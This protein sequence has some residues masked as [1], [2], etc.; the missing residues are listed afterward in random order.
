[1]EIRHLGRSGLKVSTL[2]LGTMNFGSIGKYEE[3]GKVEKKEAIELVKIAID[4]GINFFDSSDIY[5]YG[6]SEEI[7]GN[8]LGTKRKEAIISTKVRFKVGTRPNDEGNSRYHIIEACNNSLRRLKTDYIDVYLLH[9]MDLHTPLEESLRAL[10]DLVRI[11]KV[12]YIGVSNYTGWQLMKALSISEKQNLERFIVYQGHYSIVSRD[13]ENEIVPLC[14]DQGLGVMVWSPLSGGFLTGKFK[15]DVTFPKNTRFGDFNKSDF[16][17]PV[18]YEKAFKILEKIEKIAQKHSVS[19]PQVS[20]NYLLEK[21]AVSSVVL[22]VRT[23][24][25]LLDN[26]N[27]K[28]WKISKEEVMELDDISEKTRPYPYW[29]QIITGFNK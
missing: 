1:M 13:L 16:V 2:C 29:H 14:L 3:I 20:I 21:K 9:E 27:L 5:S 28:E 8:A 15:K 10:D 4:N 7:L 26:L 11:G 23:K 19:I 6:A 18:D 12:R 25:Q 22:G 17:P 24:E